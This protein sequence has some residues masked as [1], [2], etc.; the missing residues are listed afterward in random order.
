M[1]I[2]VLF[3]VAVVAIVVSSSVIADCRGPVVTAARLG[4][5][6][7]VLVVIHFVTVASVD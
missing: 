6:T 1:P 4:L 3:V 2:L 5:D 7:V